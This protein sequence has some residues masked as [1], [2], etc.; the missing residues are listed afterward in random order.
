MAAMGREEPVAGELPDKCPRCGAWKSNRLLR[1]G[2][3]EYFC[4][5]RFSGGTGFCYYQ[6]TICEGGE[7]R[8]QM[9]FLDAVLA[10]DLEE[11]VEFTPRHECV[12]NALQGPYSGYWIRPGDF[13]PLAWA[14]AEFELEN[15]PE[16]MN[17][18]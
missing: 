18:D 11:W 1:G 9:K 14:I 16:V 15:P 13:L 8:E 6:S 17:D 10:V 7:A 2:D 4:G 3:K 5:S 12:V